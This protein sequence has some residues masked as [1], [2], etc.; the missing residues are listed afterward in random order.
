M[1]FLAR[2]QLVSIETTKDPATSHTTCPSYLEIILI[3]EQERLPAL[4]LEL[5]V[6]FTQPY[7]PLSLSLLTVLS[8]ASLSTFYCKIVENSH[9]K[10]KKI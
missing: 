1:A 9:K 7:P 8:E 10:K 6:L 3:Y 2:S 5:I 4:W